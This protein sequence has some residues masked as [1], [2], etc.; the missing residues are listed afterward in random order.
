MSKSRSEFYSSP[1]KNPLWLE[2]IRKAPSSREAAQISQTGFLGRRGPLIDIDRVRNIK[3]Y[4]PDHSTA[5]ETKVASTVGLGFKSNAVNETLGPLCRVSL[6]DTMMRWCLDFFETG[7]GYL[8]VVRGEGGEIRGLYHLPAETAHPY[9]EGDTNTYHWEVIGPHASSLRFARFGDK[10]DMISRLG[11]TVDADFVAEVIHAPFPST[12]D[13]ILGYP[14]W[15]AGVPSMELEQCVTQHNFDFFVNRAVP[16]LLLA[17]M[18]AK[19]DDD[20]WT[21]IKNRFTE[22]LGLGRQRKTMALNVPDPEA[23]LELHPLVGE[24]GQESHFVD[25]SAALAVKVVSAHRVPPLLAGIV[26]PGKMSAANEMSNNI[27]AFQTLVIEQAQR[28]LSEILART[29][30]DPALNGGLGLTAANFLGEGE[31]DPE[32]DPTDPMGLKTRPK[33]NGGNGFQTITETIDLGQMDTVSRMKS[34]VPEAQARGRDVSAG[35]AERGSDI[36]NK[37]GTN[38]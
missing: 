18:G 34:S 9:L 22:H 24:Q 27:M 35:L 31:G 7:N 25:Y 33:D 1:F 11:A 17:I 28:Q 21:E 16:E 29:L 2:E 3:D 15:L 38:K 6:L 23:K 30:G 19:V 37:R 8:E 26:I 20:D 10:E 4:N 13:P 14:Q 36:N 32:P 12:R 5:L